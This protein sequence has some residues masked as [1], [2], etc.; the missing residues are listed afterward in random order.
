MRVLSLLNYLSE[1]EKDATV[2]IAVFSEATQ[3]TRYH[4]VGHLS[5]DHADDPIL[6]IEPICVLPGSGSVSRPLID[7]GGTNG[8]LNDENDKRKYR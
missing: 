5:S 6:I 2:F 8:P 1:F 3:E 7:K 4:T